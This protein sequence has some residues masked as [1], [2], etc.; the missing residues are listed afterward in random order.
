MENITKSFHEVTVLKEVGI[1]L[2]KGEIFA[3]LGE[4]GA[5]KSTLMKILSGVYSSHEFTG[6][7]IVNGEEQDFRNPRDA[8]DAGI[9]MIYQEIN[10]DLDLSVGENIFIGHLPKTKLGLVDWKRIY[11][12]AEQALQLLGIELDVYTPVR[13]LSAS[14]QQLICI[15]RSLV[16]NPHVL[17]LD[18]P[19]AALTQTETDFLMDVLHKLRAQ[20]ISCIYISHK[21]DEVF[22]ISDRIVVLRDGHFISEYNGPNYD[23]SQIIEDIIG[24][25]MQNMYPTTPKE[26]GEEVLKI[27]HFTVPHPYN[28]RADIVSDISFNVHRGEVLGLAG[29][30]GSGR[31]ETIRAMFGLLKKKS[32]VVYIDGVRVNIANAMLA[33]KNSLSLLTED[34]KSDGYVHTMNISQNLTL[35]YIDYLRKGPFI[36][37][38]RESALVT[39]YAEKLSIKTPSRTANILSL[40]G[41]N[42]QKVILAKCLAIEPKVLFLDEP[43]RGVDVGS[44][45]EIYKIIADL[46]ASGMAIVVIS[47]E[48]PELC[49]ICDRFIVLSKGRFSGELTK[50]EVSQAKIMQMC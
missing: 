23:S 10:L 46:A 18:E 7:I 38:K 17:I 44:K 41:G 22:N 13:K 47:S 9:A 3:I 1:I 37:R 14:I 21:L 39:E 12:E 43:T 40:S 11:R 19:T 29:L 35:G 33:H 48:L 25:K 30:V 20:G 32:G 4:N 8:Q 50:A 49:A 45:S 6:K 27:E 36:D 16:R 24:R 31:T 2:K 28:K 15:A 26:I 34:R 42:Q 5:G